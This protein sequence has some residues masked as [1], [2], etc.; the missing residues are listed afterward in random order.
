MATRIPNDR[1]RRLLDEAGWS[2]E[3]LARA[4]NALGAEAGLG[5][6]YRRA[7]VGQ[8]LS[9]MRPAP[10]VAALVA[11]AFSRELGR[12]VGVAETGLEP[13]G[14]GAPEPAA[15]PE[16][17]FGTDA[18]TRLTELSEGGPRR[19]Q[20]LAGGVY[21]LAALRV[22]GWAEAGHDVAAAGRRRGA[23]PSAA[24]TPALA[25]GWR[26]GREE[27]AAA[28]AMLRVF[29]DADAAFGGGHSRPA[30]AGYLRTVI[31]PALRA[32][33]SP[34]VRRELLAVASR[35]TYLCG[36]MCFDEELHG[37]AEQ[38]YLAALRLAAEAGYSAGYAITLRA[39]S[40]Q[41]STLNHP[42]P[43]LHL[44]EAACTA[45]PA[46]GSARTRAFLF[47]QLAVAQAAVGDQRAAL[48]DL[49]TAEAHLERADDEPGPIGVYHGG[50]L[51]HQHAA[52]AAC[53]GEQGRA[54]A[55]LHSSMRHRPPD[56]RRSRAIT[57]ARLAE[58]QLAAGH[59]EA[60]CASWHSFCDDYPRLRS[61]R[62]DRALEVLRIRTAAHRGNGTA[63]ALHARAT[64]L[65][66]QRRAAGA[67]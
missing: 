11:E 10:A 52:V 24:R 46:S 8:W 17:W 36:F 7:S 55:A 43:A 34:A 64:A 26:I 19:R 38:Y 44:A 12:V 56:E 1:L 2:G 58:L 15:C 14:A 41:A 37:P 3:R 22:P 33:A 13:R 53:L 31:A 18:A 61:G 65:R 59:L 32:E 30:L 54:I 50:A 29:S 49:G 60:A 9:G 6:Q 66:A 35:L 47:G 51:G 63:R 21:S 23:Q 57:V 40:V 45:V 42:V 48:A 39:M 4:V 28:D 5:L 27:V 25:P 67:G 16:T 20:A 62:V